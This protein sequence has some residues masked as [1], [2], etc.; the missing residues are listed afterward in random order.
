MELYDGATDYQKKN[1]KIYMALI[2]GMVVLAC[3]IILIMCLIMYLK[4]TIWTFEVNGQSSEKLKD[5]IIFDENDPSKIYIPIREIAD[6][7]GYKSYRGDYINLSE[8]DSKCYV[9]T[10]EEV[11]MFTEDSNIIMVES[12]KSNSDDIDYIEIE[13]PII[14]KNDELCTTINGIASSLNM[15]VSY[16]YDAKSLKVYTLEYLYSTYQENASK[17]GFEE[18]SGDFTNCK[19]LLRN[20]L[21]GKSNGYYGAYDL[22]TNSII[23]E[24]KYKN[25]EYVSKANDFIVTGSNDKVGVVTRDK[26]NKINFEYDSIKLITEND[27]LYYQVT[28]NNNIGIIDTDGNIILN[29]VVSNKYSQIG[30][31]ISDFEANGLDNGFV[32][33]D[34]LVPVKNNK[35]L[36]GFVDASTGDLVIECQYSSLGC[37]NDDDS[38]ENV[39]V[40]ASQNVIVVSSDGKYDVITLSGSG[41]YDMAL[42]SVYMTKQDVTEKYYLTAGSKTVDAEENIATQVKKKKL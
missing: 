5:I 8:E 33:L 16:D 29:P 23:M 26:K 28:L 24:N 34:S 42:D 20:V 41:V 22:A 38:Q 30:V 25:V 35:N 6:F 21:V 3:L 36:W 13:E 32:L 9:K 17:Y 2:I 27:K 7:V 11:I 1:K 4:S 40:I 10:D 12:L 14:I 15:V 37:I 19:A 18:L 31:D 39:L